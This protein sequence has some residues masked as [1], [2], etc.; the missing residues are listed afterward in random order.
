VQDEHVGG[1]LDRVDDVVQL[2]GERIDV[3]TVKG[4]MK[5][6]LSRVRM[7]WVMRSPSCSHST[8]RL[9]FSSGS[10]KSWSRS[11]SS[12]ADWTT[13]SA[14]ASNRSKKDSSRGKIRSLMASASQPR[15]TGSTPG[16]DQAKRSASIV[17]TPDANWLARWFVESARM[18]VLL[19]LGWAG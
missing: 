1:L 17:S 13:L 16:V 2:G 14:A 10:T 8:S 5:V 4:V 9:A 11:S 15:V 18:A 12:R 3:L 19:N 7:A 6:E